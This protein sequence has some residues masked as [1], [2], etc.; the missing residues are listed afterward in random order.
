MTKPFLVKLDQS[1]TQ[2]NVWRTS[3][4]WEFPAPQWVRVPKV[5]M[6]TLPHH[7]ATRRGGPQ[8][9]GVPEKATCCPCRLR[10]KALWDKGLSFQRGGVRREEKQ[11]TEEEEEAG[12]AAAAEG[13]F[14]QVPPKGRGLA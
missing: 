5:P 12:A 8:R 4:L 10:L 13:N 2:I 1:Q 6:Q 14:N 11:Q 9:R 7:C 3:W